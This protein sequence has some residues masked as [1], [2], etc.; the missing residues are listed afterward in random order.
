VKA[1]LSFFEMV[2]FNSKIF[3][4]P[5]IVCVGF[6]AIL[7][8]C[9]TVSQLHERDFKQVPLKVDRFWRVNWPDYYPFETSGLCID[10]EG[11]LLTINDNHPVVYVLHLDNN[12]GVAHAEPIA[13]GGQ[14][15]LEGESL[16][17][18]G[19]EVAENGFIYI[20]DERQRRLIEFD[21]RSNVSR[22][23]KIDWS[24]VERY[25]SRS[26]T[27]ASFEGVTLNSKSFFIANERNRGRIIEIDRETLAVKKHS[28]VGV[29]GTPE[30]LLHYS[31]L[32]WH[33][34]SLFV[35]SRQKRAIYE[36]DPQT[37]RFKA[38]F[39]FGSIE[40][41][42]SHRYRLKVPLAG[43]MEGL[44]VDETYFWL[45]TDN[46]GLGRIE[47]PGDKRPTLFRCLRP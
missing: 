40:K 45:I 39:E 30:F 19:L 27:N 3:K 21:P 2:A 26:D 7:C 5:A 34:D 38:V 33:G 32:A 9:A 29:D 37:S 15:Q 22:E 47:A 14:I 16:D 20:C 1:S 18:E 12:E 36:I 41:D 10:G 44:A 17:C 8:S 28:L 13:G 46:N 25:F 23:I 4:L 31:G 11:A 43:V 6:C 42:E 35:L 24:E